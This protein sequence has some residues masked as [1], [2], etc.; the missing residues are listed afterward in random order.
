MDKD[1]S[2]ERSARWWT[3][4]VCRHEWALAEEHTEP[5]RVQSARPDSFP[6]LHYHR[7][8]SYRCRKCGAVKFEQVP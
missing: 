6:G 8:Q 3:K 4:L 1:Y 7:V 2:G 5:G